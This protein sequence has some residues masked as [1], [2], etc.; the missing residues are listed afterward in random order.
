MNW[1]SRAIREASR[2]GDYGKV[3]KLARSA[4][5]VS[6]KQLGE[7]CGTSQ[8]AVSRLEMRGTDSYDTAQLASAAQ[9]LRIPP[10][11]VGLADHTEALAATVE[12]TDVERRNFL[13]GAA[14]VAAAPAFATFPATRAEPADGGQA[15]TLRLATSAFRRMDGSTAS[16]LLVEPV[17]AHLRFAQGLG[18]AAE[19]N[20]QRSRL[21]AVGSEVAGLAAWLSWDMGDYGSARTWYGSS[22]KAAR[23]AANPLLI[24]YQVGS[25]AQFEAHAG[26]A[27]QALELCRTARKQLGAGRPHIADAWLSSVEA[28]AHAAAGDEQAAD[29]ALTAAARCAERITA[30]EPPPWPWV[31]TFNENKVAACR[32]SC[33]ARLGIPRWVSEAQ[34]SAGAVM[35]AGHEKQRALLA[36]DVASGH[37]AGGRLDAAFGLG[38]RALEVG[39]RY[40]SGRIVE[41]ARALRRRYTSATPAKIV[42]DFDERLYGVFL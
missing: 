40:K 9:H 4:Q 13:A 14:A 16:R 36:L 7:A 22:V 25:L 15:A 19:T 21:A 24:A 29:A 28:L 3:V 12:G 31:F 6:Q 26:N 42:R 23:R 11:L 34:D 2:V 35:T 37:L 10:H 27:S 30:G 18:S 39:L 32:V 38:S 8:S 5:R 33:G 1:S 17:L 20:E 41:R